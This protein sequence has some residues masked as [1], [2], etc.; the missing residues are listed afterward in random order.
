MNV[1]AAWRSA[2][3][4]TVAVRACRSLTSCSSSS[5]AVNQVLEIPASEIEPAP[6]FGT[7]IRRDFMRGIGKVDDKFVVLLDAGHVLT[8]E[9]AEALQ[10]LNGCQA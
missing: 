2:H 9:E 3:I 1:A 6:S 7:K 8:L 10:E 5:L 4:V